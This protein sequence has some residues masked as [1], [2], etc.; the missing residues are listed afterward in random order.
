MF[1]IGMFYQVGL[2]GSALGGCTLAEA[3]SLRAF[4]NELGV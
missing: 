1:I 4:E 3:S 2:T